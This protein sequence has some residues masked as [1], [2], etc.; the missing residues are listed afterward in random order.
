MAGTIQC[1]P[2]SITF[3]NLVD[4]KAIVFRIYALGFFHHASVTYHFLLLGACQV[5]RKAVFAHFM[6]SNSENYAQSNWANDFT[7][8]LD[9]QNDMPLIRGTVYEIHE[10]KN[11]LKSM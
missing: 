5:H 2:P 7:F 9:R 10:T 6:V 4:A 11:G 8:A 1:L 3:E